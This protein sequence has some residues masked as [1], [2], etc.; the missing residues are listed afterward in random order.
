MTDIRKWFSKPTHQTEKCWIAVLD[1]S[2]N[3]NDAHKGGHKT[4]LTG[5]VESII[6]L[7]NWT[8]VPKRWELG[9]TWMSADPNALKENHQVFS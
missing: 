4:K 1:M 8:A 3:P 6:S 9:A 7:T 5:R 2:R